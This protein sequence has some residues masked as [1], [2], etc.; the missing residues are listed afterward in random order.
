MKQ[1]EHE[2]SCEH[3][4]C[5]P[6]RICEVK[7]CEFCGFVWRKCHHCGKCV[8]CKVFRC[9]DEFIFVCSECGEVFKVECEE[10]CFRK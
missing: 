4:K 7:K 3:E 8:C 6:P 1:C 10:E 5:R 2:M 9:G